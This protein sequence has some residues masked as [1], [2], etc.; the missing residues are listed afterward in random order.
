MPEILT[1]AIHMD[2]GPDEAA[3]HAD[4]QEVDHGD[5]LLLS[6]SY[7][8]KWQP[9]KCTLEESQDGASVHV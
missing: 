5:S 2:G 1:L 8:G 9:F 4:L 7:I 3:V 6:L